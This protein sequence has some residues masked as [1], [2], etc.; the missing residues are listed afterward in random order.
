MR[1]E[2]A[3][4]QITSAVVEVIES[5]Q[6]DPELRDNYIE[7]IDAIARAMILDDETDRD[8]SET[9]EQLRTLHQIRR[10]ILTLASPPDLDDPENDEAVATI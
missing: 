5:L 1:L 8:D 6:T 9:M 4:A 2:A 10:D 3:G 7:T